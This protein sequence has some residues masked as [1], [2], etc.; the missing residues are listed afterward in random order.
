MEVLLSNSIR[1][2]QTERQREY[3]K[4]LILKDSSRERESDRQ[5]GRQTDRQRKKKRG[6]QTD[7]QTDS[8]CSICIG[9]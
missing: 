6:R 2:T 1:E 7:R 4:T 5:T 9:W 8:A 3:P